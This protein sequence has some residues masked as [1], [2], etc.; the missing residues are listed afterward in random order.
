MYEAMGDVTG[1]KGSTDAVVA[2]KTARLRRVPI[3][4]IR[5]PRAI[6]RRI[7]HCG[8][9]LPDLLWPIGVLGNGNQP[10][11]IALSAVG[12][13]ML[14]LVTLWVVTRLRRRD[15]IWAGVML[16]Y[17]FLVLRGPKPSGRYIVVFAPPVSYTHLTLPT[18]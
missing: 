9:W 5:R 1:R 4:D 16:Y 2:R 17:V 3:G 7:I 13:A 10:I 8:T 12:I 14:A 11:D 6:V 15:W 18:N